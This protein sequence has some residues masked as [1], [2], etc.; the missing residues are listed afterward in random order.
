MHAAIHA[1]GLKLTR[2][3][4]FA[5]DCQYFEPRARVLHHVFKSRARADILSGKLH[6]KL[7]RSGPFVGAVYPMGFRHA[8][9]RAVGNW[10]APTKENM[11]NLRNKA[12]CMQR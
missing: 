1:F 10:A 8:H 3:A 12:K 4:S 11:P 7:Y 9:C 5:F 6:L 2:H